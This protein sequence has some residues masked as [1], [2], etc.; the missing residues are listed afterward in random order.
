MP[1]KNQSEAHAILFVVVFFLGAIPL[2]FLQ[3]GLLYQFLFLCFEIFVVSY[4]SFHRRLSTSGAQVLLWEH[5]AGE[6]GFHK[7]SKRFLASLKTLLGWMGRAVGDREYSKDGY[8]FTAKSFAFMLKLSAIYP[9]LLLL[10]GWTL[11]GSAIL[12]NFYVIPPIPKQA[13][14]LTLAVIFVPALLLGLLVR[15][16]R[17]RQ[18]WIFRIGL[19]YFLTALFVIFAFA[20]AILFGGF[21]A[22][23]RN[24]DIL[25]P[26][27]FSAIIGAIFF[28]A[29]AGFK[30]NTN[31]F[32]PVPFLPLY[33]AVTAMLAVPFVGRAG[34]LIVAFVFSYTLLWDKR[35]LGPLYVVAVLVAM[36]VPQLVLIAIDQPDDRIFFFAER[37][38]GHVAAA[39]MVLFL[40]LL[41]VVNAFIDWLSLNVT[42][43][44]LHQISKGKQ[45]L[46]NVLTWL[47]LDVVVAFTL[48]L[49]VLGSVIGFAVFVE[50][51]NMPDVANLEARRLDTTLLIQ[52]IRSVSLDI[53]NLWLVGIALTG[54]IPSVLSLAV[55]ISATAFAFFGWQT[56]A[57]EKLKNSEHET[58]IGEQQ[59]RTH[60][61]VARHL[62][63]TLTASV[64]LSGIFILSIGLGVWF[65]VS[66]VF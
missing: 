23:E 61:S 4:I 19:T 62:A 40:G 47:A 21:L 57:I 28:G 50:T 43:T 25:V 24:I 59:E 41:P 26:L 14:L 36:V 15:I 46:L 18:H 31:A 2:S 53:E 65:V 58:S 17:S 8:F 63:A 54:L 48:C 38:D 6:I 37:F 44:I 51:F 1:A 39:P 60:K 32:L 9:F 27:G 56:R 12:A 34:A 16:L 49:V 30:T 45:S 20:W 33:F 55:S 64:L 52:Q 13:L 35:G 5:E 11:G 10:L 22:Y 29:L 42:R 66:N 7:Y 3:Y